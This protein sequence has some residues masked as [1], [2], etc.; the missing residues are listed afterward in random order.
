VQVVRPAKNKALSYHHHLLTPKGKTIMKTN[1]K[2]ATMLTLGLGVLALGASSFALAGPNVLVLG[3]SHLS[4]PEHM[5]EPLHAALTKQGANVHSIG[6]CGANAADWLAVTSKGT[7]CSAEKIGSDA[8]VY[9]KYG[10]STQPIK[11]I[12]T[13]D[14][15]DLVLVVIGDTMGSYDSPSFPKAWAW[16]NITSLTKELKN[17]GVQCVWVGPAW[18]QP[19]A[20]YN[21]TDTRVK[22]FVQF[23]SKNV[24][25]CSFIDST[26]FSKPGEWKTTDGQHFTP[27]GYVAWA[28]AIV[29]ATLKTPAWQT[30]SAKK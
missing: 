5:M 18:G 27:P 14:K 13:K 4:L 11:Q 29:N 23:L 26:T 7:E 25:P 15:V 12:I 21:K 17:D 1:K 30:V 22:E 9:K 8:T 2:I 16:Q 28:N 10:S 24:A 19:G 6:V 3:E 20:K